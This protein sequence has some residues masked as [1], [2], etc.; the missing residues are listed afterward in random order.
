MKRKYMIWVFFV[1]TGGISLFCSTPIPATVTPSP[2]PPTSTQPS[3]KNFYVSTSGNDANNGTQANPWRTIQKAA[4]TITSGDTVFVEEGEYP[5]HV[6][7]TRSGAADMP[8]R[9]EAEGRV[10]MQGFTVTAN[11]VTIRGFEITDTPDHDRNGWGIWINGD[12]CLIENNYLHDATRGGIVLFVLPGEETITHDCV[13]RNNRLYRNSQ[14][15]IAIYGR[16]NLVEGNEVWGTIQYHPKWINPP[17]WVDA[18]GIRFFGSGHIIRKNYVHDIIFGIPE[19]PTPHIDCFQTWGDGNYH[20]TASDITI[21]QNRCLN[22]QGGT[23]LGSVQGFMI[24]DA[25]RVTIRNNIV[26]TYIVLNAVNSEVLTIVNNTFTNDLSLPSNYNPNIIGLTNTP[27]SVIE[28]NIFFE[29]L[30]HTIYFHD[31]MSKQSA[32][33][34]HNCIFRSD[35]KEPSGSPSPGD[36]WMVDPLFVSSASGDFHLQA[37]SPLIDAGVTIPNISNDFDDTS[38][39]IGAGFDIGAYEYNGN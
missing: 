11:Y 16:N 20:E 39:P 9:F 26:R 7:L 30:V 6:I 35:G 37:G 36:L 15:G 10:V 32:A 31:E 18:D 27:H 21:E 34:G 33:I 28:N 3:N 22:L 1:L 12:H 17:D 14:V 29:P 5:E 8:I 13:V 23:S 38:R 19:N 24:S 2:R 4:N 25:K